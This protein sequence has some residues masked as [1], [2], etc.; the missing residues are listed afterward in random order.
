MPLHYNVTSVSCF[1]IDNNEI[2]PLY[3]SGPV[4]PDFSKL[5]FMMTL[6]F[7]CKPPFLKLVPS[8]KSHQI[9]LS[10]LGHLSACVMI[11]CLWKVPIKVTFKMTHRVTLTQSYSGDQIEN[12]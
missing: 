6:L 3:I 2:F 11:L 5:L 1:Q 7:I 8:H 12:S 10:R 4:C 9:G